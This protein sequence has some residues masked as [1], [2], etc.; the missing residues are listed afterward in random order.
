MYLLFQKLQSIHLSI[1]KGIVLAYVHL[2]QE[3]V[4]EPVRDVRE[5]VKMGVQRL[6][7]EDAAKAV[8]DVVLICVQ[9]TV[10][11][12]VKV[13]AVVDVLVIVH[14][15]AVTIVV[16]SVQATVVANVTAPAVGHVA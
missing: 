6:V 10:W 16:I 8:K 12:P 2:A 11:Q 4:K 9:M 14:M 5:V 15:F 1:A 13:V 3:D 7:A